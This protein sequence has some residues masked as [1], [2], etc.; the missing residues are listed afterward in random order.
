V[1]RTA[2]GRAGLVALVAAPA[3]SMIVLDFDGT[4]A[5]IVADPAAARATPGATAAVRRLASLAGTVAI[6][7]GRPAA[8]AAEFAGITTVA[9]V[10]VLGHYGRQRWERGNLTG[11]EAPPGLAAVRAELPAVLAAAGADNGTRV[12]DKGDAVAVHTRRAAQPEAELER[13]SA[14]LAALAARA[15]LVVEPGRLV[16]ELRPPGANKGQAVRNL[17]AERAPAAI[18]FC[19]DDLGD[20]PAFT[21]VRELRAGGT[22]GLLVCSGSAEV[23]QLA[24]E[25]DLVVDGPD[26]VV[27]LLS[28]LATAFTGHRP[29]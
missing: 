12:E 27:E 22:P 14:P 5:P 25:A 2:G 29:S 6:I 7:T 16:L 15:G 26:G 1:P 13:L 23:P 3:Q 11:P 21:A 28:A 24:A 19:G 8:D 10:I 9:G 4:L 17:A 18:M 20:M